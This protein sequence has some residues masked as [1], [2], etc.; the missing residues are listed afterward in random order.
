MNEVDVVSRQ[1]KC[2]FFYWGLTQSLHVN[3]KPPYFSSCVVD[4]DSPRSALMI[5][6]AGSCTCGASEYSSEMTVSQMWGVRITG[7]SWLCLEMVVLPSAHAQ[8]VWT[9]LNPERYVSLVQWSSK[10]S[11]FFYVRTCDPGINGLGHGSCY[12]IEGEGQRAG[13]QAGVFRRHCIN[14]QFVFYVGVPAIPFTNDLTVLKERKESQLF[15]FYT[16][17]VI[18][19][20]TSWHQYIIYGCERMSV[21]HHSLCTTWWRRRRCSSSVWWHNHSEGRKVH[22]EL[23]L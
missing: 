23:C 16:I 1:S 22:Q 13:I 21:S 7:S 4:G 9:K 14:H 11:S 12:S 5:S 18:L 10:I 6:L 3:C 20:T 19:R 2:V 17:C 15:L 8:S